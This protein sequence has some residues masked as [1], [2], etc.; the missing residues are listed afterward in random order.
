MEVDMKTPLISPADKRKLRARKRF[1]ASQEPIDG[2]VWKSIPEY[3]GLYEASTHGRI[4]SCY[5]KTGWKKAI[6][7]AKYILKPNL[8]RGNYHAVNVWKDGKCKYAK[9]HRLVASAFFG[10]SDLCVNHKD[11]NKINNSVSNLEWVSISE[12]TRHAIHVLK[13][14]MQLSNKLSLSD[15]L[16]IK[17]RLKRGEYQRV[18]AQSYGVKQAA[19]S[20]IA[21]GK[22]WGIETM[23]KVLSGRARIRPSGAY[24]GDEGVMMGMSY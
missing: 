14:P 2:E 15:V 21:T 18:I 11:G 22:T 10:P 23:K 19:I 12:N 24:K 3:E 4:R 20:D 1:C 8:V 5:A 13:V 7:K 16:A 17:R 6:G 9:V